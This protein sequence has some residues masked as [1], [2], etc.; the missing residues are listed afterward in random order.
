MT[1]ALPP[2]VHS[3]GTHGGESQYSGN[4]HDARGLWPRDLEWDDAPELVGPD[5][6]VL[7]RDW[8]SPDLLD[9]LDEQ[10]ADDLID[11]LLARID[12]R[13]APSRS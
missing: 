9:E 12:G 5:R 4:P 11:E 7:A 2:G 10:V 6:A 8:L 1:G 3:P 13:R